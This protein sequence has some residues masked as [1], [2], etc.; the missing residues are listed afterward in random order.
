[1]ALA[2]LFGGAAAIASSALFVKVSEAGPVST[3][4]WRV[5]L[6][7][8]VLWA[9]AA[10]EARRR[11]ST[12]SPEHVRLMALAGFFFAGDLAVWNWSVVLTSVANATLLAN[13]APIFVTLT[14]WL[15][16]RRR[17][18]GQFIVGLA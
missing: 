2:A 13:V 10:Y 11:P 16:F 18:R 12:T 17:P 9:W 8:P 14:A 7:L 5:F 3:A 6:A 1:L 4:F 15:V